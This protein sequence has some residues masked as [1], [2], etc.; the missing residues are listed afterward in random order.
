[1]SK[2]RTPPNSQSTKNAKPKARYEKPALKTES[3]T[4]VAA[5]CN[6]VAGAGRKSSTVTPPICNASKLKS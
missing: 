3:L 5:I 2:D 1:M 4:V 6:G